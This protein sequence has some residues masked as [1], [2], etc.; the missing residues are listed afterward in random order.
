[1][2]PYWRANSG[3]REEIATRQGLAAEL[4]SYFS[5]E[6]YADIKYDTAQVLKAVAYGLIH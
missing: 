4:E 1:M 6:G 3:V 5:A 2:R